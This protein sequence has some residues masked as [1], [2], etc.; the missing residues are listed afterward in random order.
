MKGLQPRLCHKR[1]NEL[2]LKGLEFAN[3]ICSFGFYTE[4][5]KE[6]QPRSSAAARAS[7]IIHLLR[8]GCFTAPL[9]S[10]FLSSPDSTV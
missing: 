3:S 2:K 4:R 8:K 1:D 7:P 10:G 5:Q 6:E 9:L